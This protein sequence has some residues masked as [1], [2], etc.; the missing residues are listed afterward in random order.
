[1]LH[2]FTLPAFVTVMAW[3]TRERGDRYY[4]RSVRDGERVRKVYLGTGE[5]ARIAAEG[6]VIR[7][8]KREG[9]RQRGREA[10]EGLEALAAPLEELDEAA[11]VLTRAV[12]VAGGYHR[13]KGVWRRERTT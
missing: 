10:V 8:A 4:Y 5:F 2:V 11:E 7:R 12:L 9:E 6:D 3:E 13:H 1:M